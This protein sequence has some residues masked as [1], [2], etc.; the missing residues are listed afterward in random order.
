MACTCYPSY[1][2]RRITEEDHSP[3]W[4]RHKVRTYLTKGADK[5]VQVVEHLPSKCKALSSSTAKKEKKK[6]IPLRRVTS[7]NR[8]GNP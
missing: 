3:G 5:V 4:V 2:N 1:A 7:A 8:K 6:N